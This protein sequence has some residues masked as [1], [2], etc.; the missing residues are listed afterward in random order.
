M[1]K[2]ANDQVR[3]CI[4][5]ERDAAIGFLACGV[6]RVDDASEDLG[7]RVEKRLLPP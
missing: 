3:C 1:P 7:G 2:R 4:G 5:E 6:E